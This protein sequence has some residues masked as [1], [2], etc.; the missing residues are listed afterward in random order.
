MISLAENPGKLAWTNAPK[1]SYY[2]LFSRAMI[3]I[4]FII[5]D[6]IRGTSVER[7]MSMGGDLQLGSY[8]LGRRLRIGRYRRAMELRHIQVRYRQVGSCRS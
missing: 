5:G 3:A 6:S 7:P 8:Q 2:K 4:I 1:E